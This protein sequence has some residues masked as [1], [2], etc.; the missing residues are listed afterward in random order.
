MSLFGNTK[1]AAPMVKTGVDVLKAAVLARAHKGALG[2]MARDLNVGLGA[3]Q[4]W[5]H[6]GKAQL[7]P[8]TLNAIAR[9]IFGD[10]VS[11]DVET[12]LLKR[13]K[14]VPL[15]APVRPPL[16]VPTP[17]VY[18]LVSP[19]ISSNPQPQPQPKGRPGW[20]DE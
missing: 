17:K 15:P 19:L 7:S 12:G 20:S 16:F 14:Q 2:L 10:N 3:L 18:P 4:E 13:T 5:A 6:G 1:E 8:E 11:Y 9:D